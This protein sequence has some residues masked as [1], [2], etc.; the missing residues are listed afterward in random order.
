MARGCRL[1]VGARLERKRKYLYAVA[2]VSPHDGVMDSLELPWVNA[3]T[4]SL[5]LPEV[6]RRHPEEFIVTSSP[7]RIDF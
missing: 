3:E 1:I 5:F 4:A 7:R 6:A 2:A